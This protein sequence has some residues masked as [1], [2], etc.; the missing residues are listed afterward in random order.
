MHYSPAPKG[1]TT[2]SPSAVRGLNEAQIDALAELGVER[3]ICAWIM[4]FDRESTYKH[5][6]TFSAMLMGLRSI[7]RI[8][9][10]PSKMWI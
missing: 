2:L 6:E 8:Y 3:I 9:R 5:T 7:S 10:H 1:A 4:L